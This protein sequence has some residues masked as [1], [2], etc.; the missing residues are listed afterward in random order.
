MRNSWLFEATPD[1][2]EQLHQLKEICDIPDGAGVMA[3]FLTHVHIGHYTGLME[4]GREV[5]DSRRIPVYGTRRTCEFLRANGPW[6]RLVE[7]KNIRL[8]EIEADRPIRLNE[9]LRV[10]PFLVPHRGEFSDT[11]GYRIEG[12]NRSALFL[13][14]IDRWEAWDR[15]IVQEVRN[16][17]I[18]FLDGTFFTA[19]EL[20]GR[21]PSEVPH[22]SLS[23]SMMR[24][25]RLP[26]EERARIHFIHLNHTNPVLIEGSAAR[27]RLQAHGFHVAKPLQTFAL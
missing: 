22:P 27:K 24:F 18:A 6:S 21:D 26:E 5:M 3:I 19:D 14:D 16:V 10:I 4:L 20:P 25:G 11:L 9:R 12:S 8:N 17:D 23:E 13:P 7:E 2:R 15:D 1:F